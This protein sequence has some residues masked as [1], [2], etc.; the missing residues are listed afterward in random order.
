M[1]ALPIS[2]RFSRNSWQSSATNDAAANFQFPS[3]R[4]AGITEKTV[5]SSATP[6]QF[7]SA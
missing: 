2:Q 3:R 6:F 1:E 4:F 5:I 7:I